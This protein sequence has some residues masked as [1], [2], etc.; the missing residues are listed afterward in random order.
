MC[1][2]ACYEKD[3]A[4]GALEGWEEGFEDAVACS[5]GDAVDVGGCEEAEGVRCP[6][7]W[8]IEIPFGEY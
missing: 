4:L 8:V 2:V 5:E 3:F 7:V 1:P 6:V